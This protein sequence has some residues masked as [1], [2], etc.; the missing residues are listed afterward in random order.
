MNDFLKSCKWFFRI[1][2]EN[3]IYKPKNKK[4]DLVDFP[5]QLKIMSFNIRRDVYKD[6]NNNWKLRKESVIESIKAN[7]P[8]II[9]MQEV[10]PHM[11]K[12]LNSELCGCYEQQSLETFTGKDLTKSYCI[13]GEGLI[14]FYK[15]G[16]FTFKN[17]KKIKLFDGRFFN[18]RRALA[19]TITN[20]VTGHNLEIINTHFCHKSPEA[21]TKSF[22]KLLN[23]YKQSEASKIFIC[24]D[25]NCETHQTE[26]GIQI[27]KDEFTFN[28][29]DK[30]GTINFFSGACGKTIDFIFSN[31]G[32]K[33]SIVDRNSYCGKQFTSD[34][35]PVI[36]MY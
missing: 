25:F 14:I 10:M 24:G 18:M 32:I 31:C 2:K 29:P 13:P 22:N 7:N 21:R 30:K 28:I 1:T 3:F 8:D 17:K 5:H 4:C 20:N 15:K 16:K 23:Y 35:W 34:H 11:A 6:D 26:S 36:N 33:T 9:C 27:F 12:Y 19:V